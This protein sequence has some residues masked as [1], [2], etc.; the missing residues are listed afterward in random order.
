MFFLLL[1]AAEDLDLLYYAG[2]QTG[3]QKLIDIATRHAHS[4]LKSLV[5]DN[6]STMH[7]CVF[8]TQTGEIKEQLT[9]QGYAD[10]STWSRGQS[11]AI[12]GFT[13]T[14]TWTRE[15]CFLE[16]A[17]SLSNYFL[18]QLELAERQKTHDYPYV[19]L[20][21]FDAPPTPTPTSGV[22]R[23]TSAGMIA[24]NGLLL[25]AQTLIA[26]SSLEAGAKYLQAALRICKETTVLSFAKDTASFAKDLTGGAF[27]TVAEGGS[28]SFDA[29]LM[30]ATVNNHEYSHR[31]YADHGL[32]YADYYLLEF[33][34]KLMRMG[35]V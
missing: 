31:R 8:D 29:I 22:L 4:I 6:W 30:H 21:D 16:A 3:D 28:D 27:P 20:W 9:N 12:L 14:Y 11:W 19:P 5:R 10:W 2:H 35:L 1:T 23:D 17:V 26:E 34:N 33:G 15:K 13:Q 7:L 25:L 32:V 24:A 18:S